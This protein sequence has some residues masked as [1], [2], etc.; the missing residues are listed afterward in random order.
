M[1]G[2]SKSSSPGLVLTLEASGEVVVGLSALFTVRVENRGDS[3]VTISSRL[4]LEEGDLRLVVTDPGGLTKKISGAGGQPDT[5][6]RQVD[7]S[8]G[9]QIVGVLNLLQTS[10]GLTFHE[11]GEYTLRAEYDPSPR[12]ETISS[13]P[14]K[15]T[16]RLPKSEAEKGVGDLLKDEAVRRAL[17]MVDPDAAG[18]VKDLAESFADT[19]DGKLARLILAEGGSSSD[20]ADSEDLFQSDDTLA[21][22]YQIVALSTPYSGAGKRLA[23]SFESH[24]KSRDEGAARGRSGKKSDAEDALKI[25]KGQPIKTED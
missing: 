14:L 5:A 4:N 21:T 1:G 13:E 24:L 15:V 25:L 7:L 12:M 3:R 9:E 11:A 22:A 16:A 19:P 6:A 17:V 23:E 10:V 18:A 8:P 20:K 2:Q